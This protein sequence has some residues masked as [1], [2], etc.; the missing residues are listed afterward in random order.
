MLK[1]IKI[2]C[3][4]LLFWS[5]KKEPGVGGNGSITGKIIAH[6]YNAT[7]TSLLGIYPAADHYV[8][9]VYG[10]K[11]G[12]DKRIK[13][14]YNGFY[15]FPFLYPGKYTIYTYSADNT[16]TQLSGQITIKQEIQL[17]KNQDFQMPDIIIYE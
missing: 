6:N 3:I 7:F 14:D 4:L 8:Y 17:S 15:R 2:S 11:V 10:D 16:G 9:I 12:Y 5:C 1:I 13:T